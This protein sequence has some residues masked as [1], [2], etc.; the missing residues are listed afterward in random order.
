[1]SYEFKRLSEVESL[2]EVPEGAKVLAIVVE[3]EQAE[4]IVSGMDAGLAVAAAGSRRP[5][6]NP[7]IMIR[8][9]LAYRAT[10]R[11]RLKSPTPAST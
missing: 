6:S 8:S 3:G 1:M 11:Q 2:P 10:L 9:C 4:E 7:A 5:S